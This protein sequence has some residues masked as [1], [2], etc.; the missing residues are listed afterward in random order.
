MSKAKATI[1]IFNDRSS[2]RLI[3]TFHLTSASGLR[4]R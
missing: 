3:D 4:M 2:C 1:D